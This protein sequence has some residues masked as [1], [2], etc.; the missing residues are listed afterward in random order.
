MKQ[1]HSFTPLVTFEPFDMADANRCLDKWGHKMGA[2]RRGA[3]A[4]GGG[5]FA[6]ALNIGGQVVGVTVTSELIRETVAGAPHIT[7]ENG[8]ELARVCASRRDVC[9]VLVRLWRLA[10]LAN[11]PHEWGVSYQDAALHSGDLY[12]FDGWTRG[13]WS[14]SGMDARSGR[15]GRDKWIWTV[16]NIYQG[17]AKEITHGR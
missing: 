16:A 14:H 2:C 8:I 13:A 6:H 5:S 15:K 11:L 17:A 3:T 7:R 4:R 10:V 12:R 9:R 1:G